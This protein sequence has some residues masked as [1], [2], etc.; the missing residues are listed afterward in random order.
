MAQVPDVPG[1]ISTVELSHSLRALS[2][3]QDRAYLHRYGSEALAMRQAIESL[4]SA[5]PESRPV[6][7]A[8]SG[9]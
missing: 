1:F 2:V 6:V 3:P 7:E 8:A 5:L 9:S 4:A